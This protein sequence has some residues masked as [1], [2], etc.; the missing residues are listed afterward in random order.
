MKKALAEMAKTAG[1]LALGDPAGWYLLFLA[2]AWSFRHLWKASYIGLVT[3]FCGGLI[4]CAGLI[5]GLMSR[6]AS[7]LIAGREG[8]A[9]DA[10]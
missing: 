3:I 5:A 8:Q 9:G 7:R 6:R 1:C 10:P 4:L 2:L